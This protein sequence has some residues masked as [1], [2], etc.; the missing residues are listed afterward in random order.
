MSRKS[1]ETW[2]TPIRPGDIYSNTN[3]GIEKLR[4]HRT[5]A[6]RHHQNVRIVDPHRPRFST[7]VPAK[8][9]P[10]P[11]LRRLHQPPLHWI[12]VDVPQL[13]DPLL[14]RPN[15]EVI[16][17]RLPKPIRRR[18]STQTWGAPGLA[19]F[20]RPGSRHHHSPTTSTRRTPHK[21][22]LQC[23]NGNRQRLPLRLAHQQMNV[24]RHDDISQNHDP[25]LK[26]GCRW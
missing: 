3:L 15:V 6:H 19:G 21:P 11:L 25:V 13:L 8:A 9:A 1:G 16:K 23:L 7:Q 2:G 4:S 22:D 18:T 14:L 10:S 24:F 17:P 26:S 12:S 20:A 5:W